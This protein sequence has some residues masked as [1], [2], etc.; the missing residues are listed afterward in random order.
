M[1]AAMLVPDSGPASTARPERGDQLSLADAL[2]RILQ[3]GVAAQG[4]VTIGLAE[5]DLLFLDLRLLLGSV[6]AIWPEGRP[7]V[8]PVHP[9]TPPQA[10]STPMPAAAAPRPEIA[11]VSMD[12]TRIHPQP[13]IAPAGAPGPSG[14]STAQGLVRLVLTLVKLLHDVLERQA[15]RRMEAG[16]LTDMQV[17]DVGAALFAQAEEIERLKR[18]FGFS[19]KDLSLDL[20]VPDGAL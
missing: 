1:P 8:Q 2:D 13:P 12:P 3:R 15:V 7:P 10:P 16:R 14:S 20:S 4:N 18:Q 11:A 19:D 9:R 5:V 17:E 6:D